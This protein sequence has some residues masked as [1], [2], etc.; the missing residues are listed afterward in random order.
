MRINVALLAVTGT[1]AAAGTSH[2]ATPIL[3][4]KYIIQQHHVCAAVLTQST[5]G[6]GGVTNVGTSFAGSASV[7]N[8]VVVFNSTAGT[9][10]GTATQQSTG[11]LVQGVGETLAPSDTTKKLSATFTN[12]ATSVTLA[13]SSGSETYHAV[14]GPLKKGVAQ[15]VSLSALSGDS[16]SGAPCIDDITLM[17]D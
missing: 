12:T 6:Q 5:N 10:S 14:Y 9:A 15:I 16:S 2:A 7:L 4:G 17:P 11:G 1:I 13:S 3:S 8:G